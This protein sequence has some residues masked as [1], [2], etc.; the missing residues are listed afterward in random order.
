MR[1]VDIADVV[2]QTSKP[3]IHRKI[4]SRYTAKQAEETTKT[5]R[6]RACLRCH[7]QR[8]RCIPNEENPADPKAPCQTCLRVSQTK[9]VIHNCPCMRFRLP[10]IVLYRPGGLNLTCR[11]EGTQVKN[12]DSWADSSTLVIDMAQGLCRKPM[13][14][15]VRRIRPQAGDVLSRFWVHD[16][17]CRAQELPPYALADVHETADQFQK[18]LKEYAFDLLTESVKDSD[19]YI[20]YTY[21]MVDI[22]Y[23][24]LPDELENA[25]TGE[26]IPNREKKLLADMIRFCFSIRHTTGSSWV[27]GK[28]TLGIEPNLDPSYPLGD[29]LSLP[30][31]IVAQFDSIMCEIVLKEMCPML[32]KH[33]EEFVFKNNPANWFTIY[34]VIFMLLHEISVSCRDRYRHARQNSARTRYGTLGRFVEQMQE[35]ANVL[36]SVWQYYKSVDLM[37]VDWN[38]RNNTRLKHLTPQ[39]VLFMQWSIQTLSQRLPTIPQTPE[40]GCW[41]HPLYFVSQMFGTWSPL[42]TYNYME[43]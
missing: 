5:R 11:W 33:L 35:G 4:R 12:V 13:T 7:I 26:K 23:H 16:G 14:I 31:M 27:S 6:M 37:N 43:P 25:V 19:E 22:H 28:E 32:L 2:T 42:R 10:S 8:V 24:S 38:N 29:K 20:R 1:P 39:Q 30:R 9:K 3:R 34:L 40:E 41:E 18:Y 15:R 36:L 21:S 17:E